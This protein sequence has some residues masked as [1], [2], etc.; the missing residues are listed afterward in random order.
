MTAYINQNG[1]DVSVC[2]NGNISI[3]SNLTGATYQWQV[4]TGSGYTNVINNSNYSGATT[5]TL[6]LS[7]I[8]SSWRGYSY[9]CIVN[10]TSGKVFTIKFINQWTGTVNSSWE[11]PGNWSCGTVPDN[12]TDVIISSGSV[13]INSDVTVWSLKIDTDVVFAVSTGYILTVLH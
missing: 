4:N 13:V 10:G 11:N 9:K 1:S 7:N 6:Q 2:P 5:S 8:P 12:N 3:Y